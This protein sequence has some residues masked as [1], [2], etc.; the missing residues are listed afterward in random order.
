[1]YLLWNLML[2]V[3]LEA[4][5][6]SEDSLTKLILMQKSTSER[7]QKSVTWQIKTRFFF[8]LFSFC[9][10]FFKC[11]RFWLRECSCRYLKLDPDVWG[12]ESM[13]ESNKGTLNK[14]NQKGRR[15]KTASVKPT[16]MESK[17]SS[18]GRLQKDEK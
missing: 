18:M 6:C 14:Q 2:W 3:L 5:S 8:P 9:Y 13:A 10:F 17:N 16:K 4:R 15:R 1:M 12:A 11:G 7:R